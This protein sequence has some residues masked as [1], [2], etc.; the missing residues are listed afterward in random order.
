MSIRHWL[1]AT[2]VA[3]ALLPTTLLQ[4]A[5]QQTGTVQGT[6]VDATTARPLPNAQVFITGTQLGTLTNAQGRFQIVNV[7][8]GQ[9]NVRVNLIGYTE[10]TRSVNVTAGQAAG[11]TFRIQE[12][13]L[14][15]QEIVVTGV[16]GATT[17][18]KLP[19]TVDKV[20]AD[21]LPVPAV[22]A[23]S[24]IQGKVVGATV[25]SG[26][27]R[28]GS[29]PSIM[30]RGPTSI[31]A[32]GRSQ[33]PLYIVD[34]VIL[35]ASI[36]DIDANDIESIE[37]VKGAA[38]ASLYGSR[39]SNGVIQITTRSGRALGSDMTR[40]TFRT[41]YGVNQLAGG[42]NIAQ[43]H[44]YRLNAS[45]TRFV[46]SGGVEF[47]W[48]EEAIRASN[49]YPATA[50]SVARQ[51][52]LNGANIWNTFQDQ[53]WPGGTYDHIGT[54][55]RPGDFSL[56][57]LSVEGRSGGTNYLASF[58]NTLQQGVMT[59][60]NGFNRSSFRLNLDQGVRDNL[61]LSARTFYSTSTQDGQIADGGGPLFTLTRM[62]AGVP[63]TT[64]DSLGNVINVPDITG[65]NQNP[66]YV[67]QNSDRAD[68]RERFL[69][70]ANLRFSPIIWVDLDA[71]LSYDRSNVNRHQF[72]F[73]GF[74]T[75]RPSST[76]NQGYVYRD[77]WLNEAINGSVTSTFRRSLGA[78]N[79]RTQLRY[80]YEAEHYDYTRASGTN[81]A[82]EGVTSLTAAREQ[83]ITRS[84]TQD[85]RSEGYYLITNLDFADRYILDALVRRDGSSLFG[86]NERWQTYYRGAAAW[87]VSEE[88]FWA[89]LGDAISEF[90][91]RYSLGTAG[92]RPRFNAQYE[93]FTVVDGVVNPQNLGN[94]NLKPEFV[95]EQEMG[96][97]ATLMNRIGLTLTY[98]H[99]E[100]RDQIL[101]VPLAG[102]TGFV[103]QWQNA[104]T[105]E[106]N[107]WEASIEAPLVRRDNFSWSTRLLFDRT[108]QTIT[109]LNVPEYQYGFPQQGLTAV[110]FAREGE[111]LGRFYGA[112]WATGCSDLP[113]GLQSD[114]AAGA[115]QQN[116]EGYLV[117]VGQGNSWR[118]GIRNNL[119]GTAGPTVRG[120]PLMWGTPIVAQ[121]ED[122]N[123]LLPLGSTMPDFNF[124]L[125]NTINWRGFSLYGLVDATM[126]VNVY[127]LPR[128]WS[129]FE[130]YSADQ[131][132][133]G[134]DEE[135]KKPIGYHSALYRQLEPP[136]SHFVEDGSFV[137]L[138][139]VSV[140]YRFGPE[141][142]ANV[143]VLGGL[144]GV[145]LSLVG[146]NLLTWTDYSGFDPEVG[147]AG[148]DVGSAAI[149][150]FDGFNYPN[151]RSFTAAVEITF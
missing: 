57:Q 87:R 120:T 33:E 147:F 95:V 133:A 149:A 89:G 75:A 107:T 82:V 61:Q 141:Q 25:I 59:G 77:G 86:A 29:A 109:E 78:L 97:D 115:F 129:Y 100:A 55:F 142:L 63:L 42:I 36:V 138:R 98:A 118:D 62:P 128:H 114:C 30:L 28:P 19:F 48:L 52:T 126:G 14:E 143:P 1:L 93:T 6:V 24:A 134:R 31:N 23:G 150:R 80:L 123:T 148:G 71:N 50:S 21:A 116:D 72:N 9:Q 40:Y 92:G 44:P 2:V 53:P 35:G 15:L 70:G 74:R 144:G 139:E 41:E 13:A 16:A 45:G 65:E 7:P 124:S 105:L 67:L 60:L 68:D 81:L 73:K 5:A 79:T 26:S 145:G 34:G 113:S 96:I 22:D 51:P 47:D 38:A 18:A 90:K 106:S 135:T 111:P 76:L 83:R 132:Q 3:A 88:P 17:R 94:A 127:N 146:R 56:S 27:G 119:W 117:Y 4:A 43:N 46:T 104:G 58:N 136:N 125:A 12:T 54:F 66:L 112:R 64:R 151:F 103:Q 108:R 99:S 101:R 84:E 130:R 140:R 110:F 49:A 137:K 32:Q 37:V 11:V 85:I 20:N 121:D 102:Y 10:E 8:A 122:G 131:D 91:L 69:G 39:A